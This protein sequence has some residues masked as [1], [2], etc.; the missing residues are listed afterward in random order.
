MWYWGVLPG[1]ALTGLAAWILI[2]RV[3]AFIRTKG[4]SACEHCPYSGQCSGR[5]ERRK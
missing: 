4:R 2:R 1:L 3:S 5:C